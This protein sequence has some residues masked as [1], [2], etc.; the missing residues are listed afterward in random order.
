MTSA[1]AK[2]EV[3]TPSKVAVLQYR[4]SVWHTFFYGCICT[5]LR[6]IKGS[7][8]VKRGVEA[9]E[10]SAHHFISLQKRHNTSHFLRRGACILL[11]EP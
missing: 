6:S 7:F 10:K 4:A 3:S 11:A 8:A 2:N 5:E 1:K 9:D